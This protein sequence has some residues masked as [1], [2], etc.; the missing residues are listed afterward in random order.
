MIHPSFLLSA[1]L[2]SS[3]HPKGHYLFVSCFY[4]EQADVGDCFKSQE[5]NIKKEPD[6]RKSHFYNY[7]LNSTNGVFTN[8]ADLCLGGSRPLFSLRRWSEN[9]SSHTP[10]A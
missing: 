4:P 6:N 1:G 2:P 5:L 10:H 7:Y 8:C 9:F 3:W